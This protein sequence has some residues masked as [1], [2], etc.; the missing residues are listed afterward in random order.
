MAR[1]LPVS[2]P[3]SSIRRPS[4]R[5]S[6]VSPPGGSRLTRSNPACANSSLDRGQGRP[7]TARL[8]H[9]SSRGAPTCIGGPREFIRISRHSPRRLPSPRSRRTQPSWLLGT[10][11]RLLVGRRSL[12]TDWLAGITPTS[13]SCFLPAG[14]RLVYPFRLLGGVGNDPGD[15][16]ILPVLAPRSDVNRP[17]PASSQRSRTL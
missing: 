4:D 5:A 7:W 12:L 3:A 8:R 2:L 17:A 6:P 9:R 10:T 11:W 15:T 13:Q 1:Q 16:A 14:V